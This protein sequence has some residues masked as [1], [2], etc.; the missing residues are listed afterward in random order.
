MTNPCAEIDI[1]PEGQVWHNNWTIR[2]VRKYGTLFDE[3]EV[4]NVGWRL[5][6]VHFSNP[7]NKTIYQ[8]SERFILRDEVN[9]RQTCNYC[10]VGIEP[11][12]MK[13]LILL[14]RS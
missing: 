1:G 8:I 7:E 2:L 9:K 11:I 5:S 10:C 13:K 14:N 6:H 3:H 12:D 4:P